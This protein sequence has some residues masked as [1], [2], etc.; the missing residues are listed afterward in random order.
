MPGFGLSRIWDGLHPARWRIALAAGALLCVLG[1]GGAIAYYTAV[2]TSG[3]SP[4]R[5]PASKWRFAEASDNWTD[6]LRT[7]EFWNKSRSRS[8]SSDESRS[9]RRARRSSSEST[10]TSRSRESR[11]SERRSTRDQTTIRE[12]T[13]R[14]I[15]EIGEPYHRPTYTTPVLRG[16]TIRY[17]SFVP[18]EIST[19][20]TM[21]VRL[22]DGYYWPVSYSATKREFARDNEICQRS[23]DTPVALYAHRNPG[24]E[25][26]SMVDLQGR[27]YIALDT[28]FM[29]RATYNEGCKCRPHAW[30]EAARQRHLGYQTAGQ[31]EPAAVRKP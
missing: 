15:R 17:Y 10:R 7:P 29:Y 6:A 2:E 1:A 18:K 28:A 23:C 30:E 31:A 19:Y 16:A 5:L 21:C 14:P 11:S 27:P 25:A 13:S 12:H 24:E 22:C 3:V 26:E 8:S 9:S 4:D 20:R